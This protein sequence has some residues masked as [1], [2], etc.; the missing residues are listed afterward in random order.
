MV[1]PDRQQP[2]CNP[3]LKLRERRGRSFH[4]ARRPVGC[5]EAPREGDTDD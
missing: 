4:V 2:F 5:G 3:M 1:I